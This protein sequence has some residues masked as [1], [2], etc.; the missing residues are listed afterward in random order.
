MIQKG[1]LAYQF[2]ADGDRFDALVGDL[3]PVDDLDGVDGRGTG[4]EVDDEPGVAMPD[5]IDSY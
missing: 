5:L 1:S 2:V 4:L 3:E